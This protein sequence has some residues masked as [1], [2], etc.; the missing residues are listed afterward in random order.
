MVSK[1]YFKAYV[2]KKEAKRKIPIFDQI[3]GLTPGKKFQ[4]NSLPYLK[5]VLRLSCVVHGQI[6]GRSMGFYLNGFLSI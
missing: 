5:C 4:K 3:H 2:V 6:D 1:D